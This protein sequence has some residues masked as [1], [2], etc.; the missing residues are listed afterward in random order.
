MKFINVTIV[1]EDKCLK[2]GTLCHKCSFKNANFLPIFLLTL[3]MLC[4]CV[5]KSDEYSDSV[6]KLWKSRISDF[7]WKIFWPNSM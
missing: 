2:H 3:L 6:S 4:T 5:L 7:F 1:N